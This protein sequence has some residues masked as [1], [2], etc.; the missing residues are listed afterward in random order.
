MASLQ[1]GIM[2]GRLSNP[3]ENKIQSFPVLSWRDEF[4][5]AALCNFAC[6]EWVFDSYSKNPIMDDSSLSEIKSLSSNYDI[7][8]NSVCADY[9]M[10][11]K[12]FNE[13][14]SEIERNLDVLRKLI[15]NC[16]KIGMSI[17]EIPLVDSSSLSNIENENELIKNL[18]KILP[19]AN[20]NGIHIVLETDMQPQHFKQF[21]EKFDY[22]VFANYDTGN[23]AFLQYDVVEELTVLSNKIKN[24]HIKDRLSHGKTVPLGMGDAKFD[25]FFANLKKIDYNGDLIIQGARESELTPK[26]TCNNYYKFVKQ[27]VDKYFK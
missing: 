14:R 23:S 24:I 15:K 27:Y 10:E 26:Q 8:V 3:I 11:K 5:E 1:I 7:K 4:K 19:F 17:L 18:N 12:L 16:N 9:F 2:Q 13:S 20:D 6:I 25:L 22:A 21:L